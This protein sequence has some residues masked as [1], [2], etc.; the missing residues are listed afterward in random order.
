MKKLQNVRKIENRTRTRALRDAQ[1]SRKRHMDHQEND[2]WHPRNHPSVWH[3]S[4]KS[5]L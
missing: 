3:A 4:S 5:S 1:P 2:M